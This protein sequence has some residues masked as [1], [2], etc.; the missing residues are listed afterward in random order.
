M[1]IF[2]VFNPKAGKERIKSKL[3][4]IIELFSNEGH[5][6]TV[7][8]TTKP[9]DAIEWVRDLSND[10]DR[11][12]CAGG[13]G[14]LD[15]VVYGMSMRSCKIPIG[16]IPAGSTNDFANSLGLL[17]RTMDA[18]RTAI[19]GRT[20]ECDM[21]KFNKRTFV[22]VAAFGLFTDV[23]YETPQDLKN[24]L[25]HAAYVLEGLKKI[26]EVRSFNVTVETDHMKINDKFIY[27]MIT[28][29][30]S[31]GGFKKI[32]GE[33]INL[34]DGLFEV[35][36]FKAPNNPLEMN[37][38]INA[39]ITRDLNTPMIYS[40]KTNKVTF[41]SEEAISWTLDGEYGGNEK[42]AVIENIN[43]AFEIAIKE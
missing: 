7:M 40:F 25:G 43:K 30:E 15:E 27:G 21:G 5:K 2:F 34:N 8:A 6:T 41:S 11:I 36:L 4:D 1:N 31:V 12:V 23:S 24:R 10:Y 16:Y 20:F 28:N 37:S 32:T 19:S 3:G 22:Y 39:L 42:E 35:T 26:T 14:T 29:S 13:D 33:N 18:A 17:V 9:G 38:L